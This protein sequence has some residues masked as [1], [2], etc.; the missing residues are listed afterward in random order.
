MRNTLLALILLGAVAATGCGAHQ[1]QWKVRDQD[2]WPM[3]TWQTNPNLMVAV[4]KQPDCVA[5]KDLGIVRGPNGRVVVPCCEQKVSMNSYG[6]RAAAC[7]GRKN[8]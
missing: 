2:G 8:Y 6:P 4:V 3:Q 7:G 5:Y 1:S